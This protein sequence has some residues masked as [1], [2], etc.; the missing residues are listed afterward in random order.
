MNILAIGEFLIDLT[1]VGVNENDVPLYAANPGGAPAN[2]AVAASRLGA[3]TGFIGAVGN[4]S[5]GRYLQKVLRQNGVNAE[6]LLTVSDPTTLAVVSVTEEGERDFRFMRGADAQLT[7]EQ[8]SAQQIA[9]AQVLHFGSVSLTAEPERSATLRAVEYAKQQGILVSYDPNYRQPLWQS[10]EEAKKWMRHPLEQ[11]DIIKLSDEEMELLT[12]C[13]TPEECSKV[14]TEKGI[15]L[16]LITLGA[17]GV[18]YSFEGKTGLVPGVK[19]TIADTN[20]AG[21]TFLGALLCCLTKK[22]NRPLD[23]LSCEKLEEM[24]AYANRAAA[25]TCSRSGAIPAMPYQNEL[26]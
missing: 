7:Q 4:D 12:D 18:F 3:Q 24:L 16:V 6:G 23:D 8:V 25:L 15:R 20:G 21:D 9:E 17:K 2:V 11:V 10:E 1:Q 14:L 26:D 19:T 5:F 13:T 22:R